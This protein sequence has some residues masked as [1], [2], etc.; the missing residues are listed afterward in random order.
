MKVKSLTTKQYSLRRLVADK[1]E[2]ITVIITIDLNQEHTELYDAT[3][4][5][6]PEMIMAGTSQLSREQF[7]DKLKLIGADISVSTANRR[8]TFEL[9]SQT[10]DVNKLFYLFSKMIQ[11]P[12][13]DNAELKR[14]KQTNHNE[15]DLEQENSK[16]I[17]LAQLRNQLYEESSRL[18]SRSAK[19]IQANLPKVKTKHINQLHLRVRQSHWKITILG[20]SLVQQSLEKIVKKSIITN[21]PVTDLAS[22]NQVK[23]VKQH[24]CLTDIPSKSN[25]DFSLGCLVPLN[26][27]DDDYHALSFGI[28]VLAKWGGFAGRLMSTVREKEGLTYGIYGKIENATANEYG[29]FRLMTFFS[30]DKTVTGLQSTYRELKEITK[31]GITDDELTRFKNINF[32]QHQLLYD[33]LISQLRVLHNLHVNDLSVSYLDE[34]T[35]KINKLKKEDVNQAISKYLKLESMIIAGAGP[36]KSVDKDIK[37]FADGV[38]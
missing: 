29:Y 10:K 21:E 23:P 14:I 37:K 22:I 13:F 38:S 4:R 31:N 8:V 30:P 12:K 27:T 1:S 19:V 34:T 15:L 32:T 11:S 16:S 7:I 9:T 26:I 5:L 20:N 6:Y 2:V 35:D 25:I 33:S 24:L 3:L 28:S 36:V 18:Y 17:A